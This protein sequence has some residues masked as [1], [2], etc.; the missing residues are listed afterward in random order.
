MDE[1]IF[2]GIGQIVYAN[3][4]ILICPGIGSCLALV[5]RNRRTGYS[6]IAH[7]FLPESPTGIQQTALPGKY[8]NQAVRILLEGIL[9]E[10]HSCAEE[11]EAYQAGGACMFHFQQIAPANNIGALNI[12]A[13]DKALQDYGIHIVFSDIGG[14][15]ARTVEFDCSKGIMMVAT[16][17]KGRMV[18][19]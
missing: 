4:K 7:V 3:K 1:K 2:V 15:Q 9:K 16:K 19:G 14:N 6:G 10:P 5:V 17:E 8:A 11:L 13:V 18:Y 12:E